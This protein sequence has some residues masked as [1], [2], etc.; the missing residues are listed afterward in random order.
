[1]H[2]EPKRRCRLIP[3]P[4]YDVEAME[5]WLTTMAAKG[6]FLE[7]NGFFAGIATF[8]C[9][10]PRPVRYRL[11]PRQKSPGWLEDNLPTEE[12]QSLCAEFGWD[13]VA[14]RGPFD[15]YAAK[16]PVA[17]ELHTD[18]AVQALALDQVRRRERGGVLRSLFWIVLYPLL[19]WKRGPLYLLV[20][21]GPLCSVLLLALALALLSGSVSGVVYLR[22]LRSQLAAG[23]PP[24][25]RAD[26]RRRARA[27]WLRR[28]AVLLLTLGTVGMLLNLWRA[29]ERRQ[30]LQTY[31]DPL[32]FA[33]LADFGLP[34]SFHYTDT[35]ITGYNTVC[36]RDNS[37]A[38]VIVELRQTGKFETAD[39]RA[40]SG[41]LMVNYYETASP[42]LA[43]ALAKALQ[44]G[45]RRTYGPDIV[46]LSLPAMDVDYSAAYS[47]IFPTLVVAKGNQVLH[48][49]FY[50]TS[51][52]T[53]SL[54]EWSAIVTEALGGGT[55]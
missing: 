33:T 37:L 16:D 15:V 6:L 29:C 51:P 9:G 36:I 35:G 18:P 11:Q 19:L 42:W 5:S 43:E 38:P 54:E 49:T 48:C 12:E 17:G 4:S 10:H 28:A 30:A 1:M 44:Q 53:L 22:R 3:C 50:Q 47:T 45:D 25:H 40:V 34:E 39:G 26:W 7:E 8:V 31:S 2:R 20:N 23:Q 27:L 24:N 13:Y 55:A 32:P 52:D 41:G 21:L 14:T 46:P